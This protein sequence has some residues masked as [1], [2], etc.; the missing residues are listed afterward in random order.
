[1]K[2]LRLPLAA[3]LS[4][5]ASALGLGATNADSHLSAVTVYAARRR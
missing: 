3:A 4:V 2:T 5:L 1:M